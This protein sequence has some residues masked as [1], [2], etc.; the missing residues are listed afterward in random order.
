MFHD[1]SLVMRDLPSWGS[2]LQSAKAQEVSVPKVRTRA[3]L[4][5][6]DGVDSQPQGSQWGP[7]GSH[8][9]PEIW[10]NQHLLPKKLSI[11]AI[12]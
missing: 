12:S 5:A 1:T 3:P 7:M 6:D 11:C 4:A 2:A 9:L 10:I 8:G